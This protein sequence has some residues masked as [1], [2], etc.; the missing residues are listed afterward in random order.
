MAMPSDPNDNQLRR[1]FDGGGAALRV[2]KNALDGARVVRIATAYFEPSGYQVLRETLRGKEVRL[3]LGRP[4]TGADKI[5]EV[6]DEFF[7][8]LAGGRV[9]ERTRA[10]EELCAALERGLFQVSVSTGEGSR[11]STLGPRYLHHHAKVYMAD[12]KSA[13]VGSSN[14]TFNGL[15]TSREA[16]ISLTDPDDVRYF[17]ER[18]DL[19]YKKAVPVAEELLDRLRLWLLVYRPFDIYMRS[20]IELYGLPS[21]AARGRLPELAGYQRPVV[22]RI[23]RNFEDY[24]GCM[25]VASTGLGKTIMAAHAVAYLRMKGQID[26]AIVL[27]PAGL[28]SM[29]GRTMRAA[30]ISSA[31]FSYYIISIDDWKKYKDIGILEYELRHADE[32]TVIILD[33]SHHLRNADKSGELRMRNRRIVDSVSRS[34]RVLLMTATPYSRKVDDIND[35]LMLLP[36]FQKEEGLLGMEA[37]IPWSV[38]SPGSLSEIPPGVVLTA[39][40]VVKYFSSRD[41]DGNRFVLFSGN[42]RRFFP[43]RMHIRNINY[44]NPADDLLLALLKSGLLNRRTASYG[45]DEALLFDDAPNGVRN[46]LFEAHIVHQFCSSLREVDTLLGKMQEEGGFSTLRF[47]SQAELSEYVH[48]ARCDLHPLIAGGPGPCEDPK[49]RELIGILRSFEGEKAVIFC[50]YRET[51]RYVA[52][53]LRRYAPHRA[54]ETTVE[55]KPDEIEQILRRFAPEANT[56]DIYSDEETP[57]T[58]SEPIDVLVATGAMSEGFNFQD[59]RLLINFD[60]PWTVLVLAQR[61]GRILRPWHEPRDV[62]IYN[63]IPSTMS[64]ESIGHALN[65]R[66]RLYARNRE[67]SSFADIPVMVEQGSEFEMVELARSVSRFGDAELELDEVFDFIERADRLRTSAFIDDLAALSPG[68]LEILRGLPAGIRSA[69]K[70]P[71]KST[72]LYALFAYR[73]RVYPALFGPGGDVLMDNDRMDEIMNLIRSTTDEEACR[74]P[75]DPDGMDLWLARSRNT[76]AAARKVMPEDIEVLCWMALVPG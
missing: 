38:D 9:E 43:R 70:A 53:C 6:I 7:S 4:D 37:A 25:L 34:A 26:S 33:E 46:P 21:E 59:A 69:K 28:K 15:V 68:D 49:I 41:G 36:H 48:A 63:L 20:L 58:E 66:E 73:D 30:R 62:Y 61:M 52:D 45:E 50:H 40:S 71:V 64:N 55:R 12:R 2:V 24:G 11:P 44:S 16:G 10:M 51:A 32:K 65:W 39:P 76:W 57:M 72:A 56:I 19:Y 75:E 18:F 14:F 22:S 35:Q 67:F 74:A 60:L 23:I 29:W 31:E 5:R 54:V 3:L 1:Y 13:V 17:V 8:A 47:A 27:C 42:Q